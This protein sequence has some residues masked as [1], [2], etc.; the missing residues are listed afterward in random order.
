MYDVQRAPDVAVLETLC[1]R[2]ADHA[3][4]VQ[5]N[6]GAA[7]EALERALVVEVALHPFDPGTGIRRAAGK[8]ADLY[9]GAGGIIEHGLTDEPGRPG[10]RQQFCGHYRS[11]IWSRWIRAERGA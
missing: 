3:G 5:D 7:D 9:S 4:N 8:G 6:A 11:T 1:V 10:N 2:R